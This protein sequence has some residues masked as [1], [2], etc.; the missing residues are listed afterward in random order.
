MLLR[1]RSLQHQDM[2]NAMKGAHNT[3]YSMTN[4]PSAVG[5][6]IQVYGKPNAGN[7]TLVNLLSNKAGVTID[8][9]KG[10]LVWQ[11]KS[12]CQTQNNNNLGKVESH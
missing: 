10:L 1:G 11:N 6:V 3:G 2:M 9:L 12:K 8:D 7:I 5:R 4:K